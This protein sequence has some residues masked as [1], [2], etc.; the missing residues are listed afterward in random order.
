MHHVISERVYL[1]LI[2]EQVSV[3]WFKSSVIK[4][5]GLSE[6]KNL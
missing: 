5:I 4:N 3:F 6:R 2:L 1:V